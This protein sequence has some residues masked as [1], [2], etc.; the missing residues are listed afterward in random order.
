MTKDEGALKRKV[1]TNPAFTGFNPLN[2][3]KVFDSFKSYLYLAESG[4]W[5]NRNF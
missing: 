2:A 1:L 4:R 5:L 3:V